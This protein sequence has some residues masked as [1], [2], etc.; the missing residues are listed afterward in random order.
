VPFEEVLVR[1]MSGS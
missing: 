1:E